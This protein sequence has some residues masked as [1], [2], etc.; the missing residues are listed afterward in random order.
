[1]TAPTPLR[2]VPGEGPLRLWRHARGSDASLVLV[3]LAQGAGAFVAPSRLISLL[4]PPGPR[5][6]WPRRLLERRQ[7]KRS[8]LLVATDRDVAVACVRRWHLDLARIRLVPDFDRGLEARLGT[9]LRGRGAGRAA[10][11]SAR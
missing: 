9:E 11:H 1:M 4:E 6:A 7:A 5:P 3:P 10:W 8:R 2:A